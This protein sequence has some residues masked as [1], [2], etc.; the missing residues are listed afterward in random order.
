MLFP[1][2]ERKGSGVWQVVPGDSV[3]QAKMM[4]EWEPFFGPGMH[5]TQPTSE[6]LQHCSTRLTSPLKDK[7]DWVL[8]GHLNDCVA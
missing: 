1:A 5:F 2:N 6:T 7:D 8:Q 4:Q 3:P